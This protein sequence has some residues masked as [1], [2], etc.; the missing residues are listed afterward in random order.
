MPPSTRG[1]ARIS[2]RVV[3]LDNGKPLRRAVVTATSDTGAKRSTMT[4]PVA[5]LFE[6]RN[7]PAGA[8][9]LRAS[10]NGYVALD[11]GED[12]TEGGGRDIRVTDNGVFDKAF[13][14]L[15]KPG[16]IVGQVLDEAG[17]PMEGVQVIPM[18]LEYLA[19][20]ARLV[21]VPAPAMAKPTNDLGRYRIFGLQPGEYFVAATPARS[22]AAAPPSGDV[23]SNYILTY[24]PGSRDPADAQMV[25]VAAAQE[26]QADF[27]LVAARTFDL[28]G[29]ARDWLGNPIVSATVVLNPGANASISVGAEVA[30]AGDGSFSFS[31]L[32]AG[33]YLLTLQP[34]PGPPP[35]SS[36]FLFGPQA[37]PLFASLVVTVTPN[38][39]DVV[40]EGRAGRTLRGQVIVE[41]GQQI[42][43][44]S[45]A[46][47]TRPVD[48]ARSP[49]DPVVPVPVRANWT[50]DL[51][52]MWG[53]QVIDVAA[54]PGWGLKAVRL[55][56]VDFTDR[57]IDFDRE[58]GIVQ[59]VVT[60]QVSEIS[61]SVTD[62]GRPAA[63][64]PVIVFPENRDRWDFQSRFVRVVN[65]DENGHFT[66][67]PMPPG[68]YRVVALYRLR[69]G[70]GWQRPQ[71]LDS[72]MRSS[73][74]TIVREGEHVSVEL[75]ATVPR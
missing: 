34:L 69:S 46:I 65:A 10:M 4:D 73:T 55:G 49:L 2:G 52:G 20:N 38:M 58:T 19:G 24:Y 57:P 64:V 27:A 54:P 12:P 33:P 48:F 75:R 13:F 59:V 7:L 8:Y 39:P 72:L 1:T 36:V 30:T 74:R 11:F 18:A 3:A 42:D 60:S 22:N 71:F 47:T 29:V 21:P 9:R 70:T 51:P 16:A 50:F 63:H 5:G 6:F 32:A 66:F 41:G 62:E 23:A 43:P 37:T 67:S 28:S 68:D 14:R 61:G 17:E 40:L 35:G 15:P 25:T 31:G 45:I 53:P 26:A 56:G 44:G